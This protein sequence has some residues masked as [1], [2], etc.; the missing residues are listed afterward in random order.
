MVIHYF[1]VE[2]KLDN[3]FEDYE[4]TTNNANKTNA[5]QNNIDA[6]VDE[7]EMELVQDTVR[8]QIVAIRNRH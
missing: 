1:I 6:M 2:Q 7:L 8:D 3:V 5:N 4:R